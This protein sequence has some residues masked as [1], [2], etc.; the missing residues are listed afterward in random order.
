MTGERVTLEMPEDLA[1]VVGEELD[2][3]ERVVWWARPEIP[4]LGNR[5]GDWTTVAM[6]TLFCAALGAIFAV[7]SQLDYRA[8]PAH[9]PD[10]GAAVAL[11]LLFMVFPGLLLTGMLLG[12]RRQRRDAPRSF[13]A[14][15][16]RRAIVSVP[17]GGGRVLRSYAGPALTSIRRV[18]RANGASDLTFEIPSARPSTPPPKFE[19]GF[20]GIRDAA[21]VERL[22][23]AIV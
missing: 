21:K 9:R 3:G 11:V 13:Y 15:T 23:R 1:A 2:E 8:D 17:G 14:I 18:D 5:K 20:F 22:L 6:V 12:H 16:D 10:R 7:M 4:T 19:Q